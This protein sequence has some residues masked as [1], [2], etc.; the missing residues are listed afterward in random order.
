MTGLKVAAFFPE[1][2]TVAIA[3]NKADRPVTRCDDRGVGQPAAIFKVTNDPPVGKR[4]FFTPDGLPSDHYLWL[5]GQGGQL[6]RG[7]VSSSDQPPP[8][9]VRGRP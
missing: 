8:R 3:G 6:L 5:T 2:A 7:E 9:D 1:R 4:P